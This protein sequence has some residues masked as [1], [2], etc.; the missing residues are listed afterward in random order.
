MNSDLLWI[1]KQPSLMSTPQGVKPFTW[2]IDRLG[3]SVGSKVNI[4]LTKQPKRLGIYYENLVERTLLNTDQ[5][6]VLKRNI[7]VKKHKTTLGE[8]DFIGR[9]GS[10][11]FHLE[12]AIKFYLRVGPGNNLSD[13]VGP[14]KKD[15]LDIKWNR[16]LEHQLPLSS[17]TEGIQVCQDHH[18]SPQT[19]VLLLQ[20][21]LFHPFQEGTPKQLADEINPQHLQGW[22]LRSRD[23]SLLGEQYQTAIMQK[24]YWLNAA[25]TETIDKSSLKEV[26]KETNFPLL[27]TRGMMSEGSWQEHDRGFIVPDSW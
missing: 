5:P 21:Y 15:R 17:C 20:G 12:C 24:P 3:N 27:V 9:I 23:I 25:I 22:W 18:L 16:M 14:G 7:Q 4:D 19:K 11:D 1:L 6:I 2:L 8:F 10:D 26:V 13:Y